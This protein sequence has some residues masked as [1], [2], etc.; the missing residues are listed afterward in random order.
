ML[1]PLV[2]FPSM[3][4]GRSG[5]L[6]ESD[7]VKRRGS[8]WD[9]PIRLVPRR[10][11]LL[12]PIV[13]LCVLACSEPPR[14]NVVVITMDTMRADALGAYGQRKPT[15]PRID[16]MAAEGVLFEDV[17]SSAP[18]T[19]P[20]HASI[21]TGKQ[22]Y[23][24]GV[25][26]NAGFRLAPDHVTLAERLRD[27]GWATRAEVA[28]AVLGHRKQLDQ[29][30][31]SYRDPGR[32][33]DVVE[34]LDPE[35]R[36]RRV[37]RSAEAITDD[38]LAF[39]RENAGRAFFL[40]LHYFDPHKPYEPPAEFA[41]GLAPYHGEIRRVDHQVGRL[42]DEIE[43]LGLR[44]RTLVLLTSDHGEGQHQHGEETHS[45][46]VYEST[47]RVPL[48]LWGAQ[49]PRGVRVP[50]LVRTV[51]VTPTLLALLGLEPLVEV[52]G[53]SLAALFERPNESLNLVGYGESIE[54]ALAF[55]SSVLR[56]VRVRRWKYIHKLRP[57]LYDV[58]ADPTEVINLIDARP[59]V[60]DRLRGRLAELLAAAPMANDAARVQLDAQQLEELRALGYIAG[61]PD[62]ETAA[63]FNSLELLGPDPN[64]HIADV[65]R[66]AE[67][68]GLM[69]RRDWDAALAAAAELLAR[70]PE[71]HLGHS[72]RVVALERAGR[73]A[74]AV[75]ALRAALLVTP[76][77]FDHLTALAAHLMR[78]EENHEAEALLRHS[79]ALNPC[80][81]RTRLLLANL[82]DVSGRHA[83]QLELLSDVDPTCSGPEPVRNAL[84]FLLATSP[85]AALRDGVRS[86]ELARELVAA[87]GARHPGYLDTL[88]A[89]YAETDDFERAIV[90]Q[91][92][93]LALLEGQ[94]L[95]DGVHES[96]A[97]H[98][99]AYRNGRPA[100]SDVR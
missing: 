30:F 29:G 98:L 38:G 6:A 94:P 8:G 48:I 11:A 27:G 42:L 7:R 61:E 67:G 96:F 44:E 35:Q 25:R 71:G 5:P 91:E 37:T 75:L 58:R 56:F 100:R 46:F 87:D 99:A 21:F 17:V 18:S 28:A 31:E 16:A 41:E 1:D 57:E 22:P 52:Q 43:S 55:G 60:A 70:Q 40:W 12:L 82:L 4:V 45:Y 68:W 39:V 13:A 33:R 78:A 2:G 92:R 50:S 23:A 76:D 32:L 63:R 93:A 20:S 47:M 80:G 86:L 83:Q 88:A 89:A 64:E 73:D 72:L 74:E 69:E 3:S 15:S 19:L 51:D 14:L 95:P 10:F 66:F 90:E 34:R 84:A 36:Y 65:Q 77:S 59:R 53:A 97:R 85:D 24:H 49:L 62:A 79:L 81:S 26:A 54:S 9:Y